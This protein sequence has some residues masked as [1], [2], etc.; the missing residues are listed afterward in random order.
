MDNST[1]R[2]RF[3]TSTASGLGLAAL[4]SLLE[5]EAKSDADPLRPRSPHFPATARRCIFVFLIGGV[6]QIDLFDPKPAMKKLDGKQIP[7]SFKKGV[8]LGQTNW[9]APIMASPFKY[10]RY[11]ACGME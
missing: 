2:R 9:N 1:T 4:A 8:R 11:G 5:Q 6:S 7:D 10:R 3:F